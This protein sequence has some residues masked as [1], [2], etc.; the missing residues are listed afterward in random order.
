MHWM[1]CSVYYLGCMVVKISALFA[2]WSITV[3]DVTTFRY[4]YLGFFLAWNS[5][6]IFRYRYQCCDD[7]INVKYIFPSRQTCTALVLSYDCTECSCSPNI[8]VFNKFLVFN[9][10]FFNFEQQF[11]FPWISI[12]SSFSMLYS[13][14]N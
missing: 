12:Q 9:F 2:E 7:Y 3:H 10:P 1:A 14:I 6:F 11:P 4:C 8:A 13:T 5:L